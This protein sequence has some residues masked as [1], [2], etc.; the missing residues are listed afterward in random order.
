MIGLMETN[1][2]ASSQ[3]R[4]SHLTVSEA[5]AGYAAN[6]TV[7]PK[8]MAGYEG[9]FVRHVDPVL[10]SMLVAEITR[11]DV[12]ALL[13][14]LRAQGAGD[15]LV[16]LARIVLSAACRYAMDHGV[17]DALPTAAVPA[18]HSR[19]VVGRVIT[20]EEFVRVR[21]ALPTPGARLLADLFVRAGLRIGEALALTASDIDRDAVLVRRTLSE[22]GRRFSADGERFALRPST[23]NG[24]E[25]RVVVGQHFADRLR[26][27]CKESGIGPDDVVF[28]ARL[29]LPPVSGRTFPQKIHLEPLTPARLAEL[30][31]FTGPNGIEY[32]H[33][34]MNGYVTGKCR[35][36]CC[37]QAI[38]EYSARKKRE[39][40]QRQRGDVAPRRERVQ[41]GE[42][43]VDSAASTGVTG[44]G[45]VSHQG[46]S[47][48]WQ[49][50]VRSAGLDF[51]PQARQTRHAYASWLN[52]GGVSAE[53]I[54]EGLG[55]QDDRSTRVYM[56]PVGPE[57][58]AVA[59]MDTLLGEGGAP[60][61]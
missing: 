14:R 2:R 55:H 41:A 33:G 32:Q 11:G 27:W 49:A 57:A 48:L 22:P 6:A 29:V 5:W 10:G 43:P 50:A 47:R 12:A 19:T 34:T 58:E 9:I 30:G 31:T 53:R 52:L 25:R 51:S 59:V 13:E 54:A 23:K 60:P 61:A 24:H 37:R 1:T 38:S 40:R 56:R 39:R 7:D 15:S 26:L 42:A 44:L 16:R 20:P 17:I 45:V 3:R 8:T 35:E 4:A 21:D 36:A 18:P 28:P 46:W